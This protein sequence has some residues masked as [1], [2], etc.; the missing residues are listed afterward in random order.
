MKLFVSWSGVRSY[1]VAVAIRDW[2]PLTLHAA[3]PFVSSMDIGPGSRWQDRIAAELAIAEFGL[4]CVTRENQSSPWLNYEAGA[5]SSALANHRVIPLAIDLE[6][7]EIVGPL[8][9]F[10]AKTLWKEDVKSIIARINECSD[11]PVASGTVHL[12]VEKWWPDLEWALRR[13]LGQ[14]GAGTGAA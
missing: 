1:C 9:Q 2:L 12:S 6:P 3:R 10:Q 14:D 11:L 8:A 4:I 13:N 7:S 5:L